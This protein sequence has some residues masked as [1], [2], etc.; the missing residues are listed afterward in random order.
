MERELRRFHAVYAQLNAQLQKMQEGAA[1]MPPGRRLEAA[2]KRIAMTQ[3]AID[4]FCKGNIRRIYFDSKQQMDISLSFGMEQPRALKCEKVQYEDANSIARP[5]PNSHSVDLQLLLA[6][7]MD[8][9]DEEA[10]AADCLGAGSDEEA[11]DAALEA[12]LQWNARPVAPD[13][14]DD[15]L[16][17]VSG[18]E[19]ADECTVGVDME[20][21]CDWER[22]AGGDIEECNALHLELETS[23]NDIEYMMLQD[24]RGTFTLRATPWGVS[25]MQCTSRRPTRRA[26]AP[27]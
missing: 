15:A 10:Q 1:A 22:T 13:H 23:P 25:E 9:D 12:E 8:E 11:G 6:D 7:Y 18:D 27:W 4:K 16:G 19:V 17:A 2:T 26:T 21:D 24:H 3:E 5:E 14:E 20:E